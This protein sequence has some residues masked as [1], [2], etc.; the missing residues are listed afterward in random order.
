M[1]KQHVVIGASLLLLLIIQVV[2]AASSVSFS[3]KTNNLSCKRDVT[4]STTSSQVSLTSAATCDLGTNRTSLSTFTQLKFYA[5]F[6]TIPMVKA[7]ASA[8]VS[9]KITSLLS[10]TISIDVGAAFGVDKVIEYLDNDGVSGYQEGNG[11]TIVKEYPLVGLTWSTPTLVKT[12]ISSSSSAYIY[13]V[14]TSASVGTLCT[15][16]FTGYLTTNEV[17]FSDSSLVARSGVSQVLVPSSYKSSLEFTG[18]NYLNSNGK[19]AISTLLAYRGSLA[20]KASSRSLRDLFA[21][22]SEERPDSASSDQIVFQFDQSSFLSSWNLS[23]TFNIPKPY[24]S[25]QSYVSK[26]STGSTVVSKATLVSTSTSTATI[27]NTNTLA[28]GAITADISSAKVVR[29]Y[30]SFTEQ[31]SNFIWDPSVGTEDTSAS[32]TS[33]AV[34][35]KFGSVLIVML[36]LIGMF[37]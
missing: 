3:L 7:V 20:K 14:T 27:A 34:S 32:S 8:G 23:S 21:T 10:T 22:T 26:Y 5:A 9:I 1:S 37:L 30:V 19:L 15:V 31:V 13:Q 35:I 16:K 36:A 28:Y 11:D 4:T 33:D 17:T 2:S 18:I 29:F 12:S 25:F 24:F 6:G